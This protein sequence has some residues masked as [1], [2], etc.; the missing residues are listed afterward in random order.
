MPKQKS[1]GRTTPKGNGNGKVLDLPLEAMQEVPPTAP[2]QPEGTFTV[3]P[4]RLAMKYQEK[5]RELSERIVLVEAAF[6]QVNDE[7]TQLQQQLQVAQS[8]IAELTGEDD[9]DETTEGPE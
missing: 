3:D 9:D 4:N 2:Q 6:E 8:R 7:R 1:T 5:C